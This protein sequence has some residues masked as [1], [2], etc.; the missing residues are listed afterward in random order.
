MTPAALHALLVAVAAARRPVVLID[1]GAGAGKSTLAAQ[2]IDAWPG[3]EPAVVICTDTICP[4]WDGLAAAAAAVPTL[5]R[6]GEVTSWDWEADRPGG[7]LAVDPRCP[8]IIEGCGAITA[9][10]SELA[11]LRV[12]VETPQD[13]RRERALARDGEIFAPHWQQWADQ[14]AEHW[15]RDR[16]RELADVVIDG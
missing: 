15:R 5:I 7:P 8:L 11:T 1:G 6:G 10:S 14:E 9:A 13:R 4:G 16:P 3:A 12:W 2:M